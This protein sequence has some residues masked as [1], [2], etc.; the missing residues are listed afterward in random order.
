[1]SGGPRTIDNGGGEELTFLGTRTDERG[2]YAEARNKVMH[3][4]RFAGAP[5][6]AK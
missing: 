2:E 3:G 4:R 6:P 1:M 5:E